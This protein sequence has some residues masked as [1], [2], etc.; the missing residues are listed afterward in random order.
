MG[1]FIPSNRRIRN[2]RFSYEPRYY[3]PERE[4][5]LKRRIRIKSKSRAQ[6]RNPAGII[7]FLVM[8]AMA[9]YIYMKLG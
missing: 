7:Y 4:E 9:L 8:L 6:R 3:N 1:L 5:R 2:R